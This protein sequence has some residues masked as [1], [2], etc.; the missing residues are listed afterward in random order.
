MAKRL[1]SQYRLENSLQFNLDVL[2]R[3]LVSTTYDSPDEEMENGTTSVVG[4]RSDPNENDSDIELI[5]CYREVRIFLLQPAAGR[6]FMTTGLAC[7]TN[8]G[9]LLGEDRETLVDVPSEHSGL[10]KWLLGNPQLDT[11]SAD[12][13]TIPWLSVVKSNH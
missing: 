9:M 6:K 3:P 8:N 7:D 12:N 11:F 13:S 2:V 1:F 5:A 4:K 10:I